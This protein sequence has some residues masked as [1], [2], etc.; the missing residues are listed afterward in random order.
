[1]LCVFQFE[2]D[3]PPTFHSTPSITY[4]VTKNGSFSLNPHRG[5]RGVSSQETGSHLVMQ[6]KPLIGV[7]ADYRPAQGNQP[8]LS[9]ITSGYYDSIIRAG[10]IPVIVPPMECEDDIQA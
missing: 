3:E 1:M 9:V 8:A 2:Y 10:A 6:R 4:P 7:N 5:S